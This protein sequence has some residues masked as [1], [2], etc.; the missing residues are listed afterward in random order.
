MVMTEYSGLE[1]QMQILDLLRSQ[2]RLSVQEIC[3]RFEI[4]EATAR[5]DL[6]ALAQEGKIQRF[7][8]GA[9]PVN[10]AAPEE[11]ILRRS[12]DQG[13]EKREIG[14]ATAALIKEN[15][16]VFLGTGTTVLQVAGF[17]KNRSL[18]VITN[19]LPIINLLSDSRDTNLISI[20]GL[21]R[22]SEQSFI[23]QT[24]EKALHELHADKV[25]VGIRAISLEHGLTNDYLSETMTDRTI[26]GMGKE[27]IVVADHTKFGCVSTI[28]VAPIEA[29]SAI[30]TDN[31]VSPEFIAELRLRNVKI[32]IAD[33]DM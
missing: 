6:D 16:T 27:I 14:K 13:G 15:E 20:G 32:V 8:G 33:K 22:R 10:Q 4:S 23:G 9:L 1:R 29:V 3:D 24:A 2:G 26:L 21:Y 7:H 11:S 18:T 30:V 28:L 31:Q 12:S 19:S 5:R 25:I 17:L